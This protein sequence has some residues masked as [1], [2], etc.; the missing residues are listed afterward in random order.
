MAWRV[1]S[2]AEMDVLDKAIHLIKDGCGL[3]ELQKLP[4]WMVNILRCSVSEADEKVIE[5]QRQYENE[6]NMLK[7]KLDYLLKRQDEMS[8]ALRISES[9]LE[10]ALSESKALRCKLDQ[11]RQNSI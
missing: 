5:L 9:L 4:T 10:A 8:S 7:A 1:I 3:Q 6:L 11:N 2:T